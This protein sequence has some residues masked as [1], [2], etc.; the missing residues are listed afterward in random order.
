MSKQ[1]QPPHIF[2]S[3][4]E[5]NK[6]LG[7]TK[8]L[9]P[10]ITIENYNDAANNTTN[11]ARGVLLNFYNIS[12]KKYFSGT[13][14]YGQNHYEFDEGGLS[15]TAPMQLMAAGN[16]N[17]DECE[18]LT[19]L[20][21]PDFLR[22]Y[23]LAEAIKKHGFFSYSVNEALHLSEKEKD[24][25]LS[26]FRNIQNELE[27]SIDNFSQDI[28]ISQLE[29]LFNY[30]ERFY[31]RQFTICKTESDD[32]LAQM[33]ML[34]NEYFNKNTG[35]EKGL[36]TVQYL[37]DKLNISSGY[38]SDML[39]SLTGLNA[40]QHIHEKL[41]EKAKEY[42]TTRNSSIAE[43]AY[44]LGFEHPQSFSKV[45]KKKTTLSPSEYKQIFS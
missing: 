45:F 10:L 37:A 18:G 13:I 33:E 20:I 26:I 22:G 31:N 23:P 5:L 11:I 39:R 15:F 21:H 2:N 12:Y 42:L 7:L 8:P 35:L 24:I 40:Q 36:P 3:I 43:V 17:E 29:L 4:A 27:Q 1:K 41:I 9:H 34:L 19:M 38:L 6:V 44:Q 30:S 16:N 28:I 14:R 25:T 32:M